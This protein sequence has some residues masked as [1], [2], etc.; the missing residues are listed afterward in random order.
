VFLQAAAEV[1]GG[2]AGAGAEPGAGHAGA[3]DGAVL[4][5]HAARRRAHHLCERPARDAPLLPGAARRHQHRRGDQVCAQL[6][7]LLPHQPAV[8]DIEFLF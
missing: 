5:V 8:S 3:A 1:G 7:P 6:L 2:A 4:R